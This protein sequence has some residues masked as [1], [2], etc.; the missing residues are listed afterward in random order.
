MLPEQ[1]DAGNEEN[2][3]HRPEDTTRRDEYGLSNLISPSYTIISFVVTSL[4]G[5]EEG[6]Y[7]PLHPL[8]RPSR[9]HTA[10]AAHHP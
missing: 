6:T 9:A 2:E 4:Q 3:R 10:C 7:C 5:R 8:D 1:G